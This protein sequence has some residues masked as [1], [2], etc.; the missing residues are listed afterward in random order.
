MTC[1]FFP[2]NFVAQHFRALA[3]EGSGHGED[4][5][6]LYNGLPGL[7]FCSASISAHD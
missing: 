6:S 4:L 7:W 5:C 3:L 1:C 2:V